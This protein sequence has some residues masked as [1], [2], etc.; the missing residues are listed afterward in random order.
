MYGRVI[1]T[2]LPANR[3]TIT[4]APLRK[5]L[6]LIKGNQ[7]RKEFKWPPIKRLVEVLGIVLPQN[8]AGKEGRNY[9]WYSFITH[10]VRQ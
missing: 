9:V 2:V 3:D 5:L 8:T 6:N 1:I 10:V 7:L 4:R